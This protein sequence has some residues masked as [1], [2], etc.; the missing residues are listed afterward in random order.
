MKYTKEQEQDIEERV[1]KAVDFLAELQLGVSAQ[2]VA[3][4]MGND[5]FGTKVYPYLQDLKYKNESAPKN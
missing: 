3:Q 4:N 2:V 1:K 5:V